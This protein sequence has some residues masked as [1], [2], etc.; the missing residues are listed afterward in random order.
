MASTEW[1]ERRVAI[2]YLYQTFPV[3]TGLATHLLSVLNQE[4]PA[5]HAFTG[6]DAPQGRV[7]I[8]RRDPGPRA[9]LF[10]LHLGPLEQP[11]NAT[12]FLLE[13]TFPAHPEKIVEELFD[14][15]FSAFKKTVPNRALESVEVGHR[16]SLRVPTGDAPPFFGEQFSRI[17]FGQNQSLKREIIQQCLEVNLDFE[18]G[19]NIP[20]P[21][22]RSRIRVTPLA[23]DPSRLYVEIIA[24]WQ[25][26]L[27]N[28]EKVPPQLR[29][30]LPPS[31]NA[32]EQAPSFYFRQVKSFV[33]N[34]LTRFVT[35]G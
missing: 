13:L 29:A 19:E 31:I 34:E 10:G 15:S 14:R 12:R 26:M 23:E 6:F 21:G 24:T 33:Q 30:S 8:W 2:A 4:L 1:H 25:R 7:R 22:A 20:L 16:A 11:R 18:T 9:S 3:E 28:I 27:L 35:G 32:Q 17:P 5:E